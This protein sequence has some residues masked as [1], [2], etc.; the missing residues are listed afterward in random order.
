MGEPPSFS[1]EIRGIADGLRDDA[2]SHTRLNR[3]ASRI[4]HLGRKLHGI[5]YVRDREI[6]GCFT[7]A[8]RELSASHGL[9]EAL[10][11][12][13]VRRAA[14]HLDAAAAHSDEGVLPTA[15]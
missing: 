4:D 15:P 13:A 10:R 5:G 2:R 8:L 9:P 3:A 6:G 7:E 1:G 14:A 12:E 11:A